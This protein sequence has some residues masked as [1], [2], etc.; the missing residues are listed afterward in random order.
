VSG[1]VIIECVGKEK[2]TREEEKPVCGRN[3]L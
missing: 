2:K 1:E 3:L